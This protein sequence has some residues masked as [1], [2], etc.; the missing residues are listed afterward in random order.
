LI[1]YTTNAAK[2]AEKKHVAKVERK[3]KPKNEVKHGSIVSVK[4]KKQNN[5]AKLF[6]RPGSISNIKI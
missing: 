6:G 2:G 1:Q 3:V 5:I 4:L